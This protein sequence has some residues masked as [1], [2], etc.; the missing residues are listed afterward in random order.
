MP[1]P[2]GA[3]VPGARGPRRSPPLQ[4]FSSSSSSS[5]RLCPEPATATSPRRR[6]ECPQER[7]RHQAGAPSASSPPS[8]PLPSPVAPLQLLLRL[9]LTSGLLSP[10]WSPRAPD[11][12][13]YDASPPSSATRTTG[14]S[15]P[16]PCARLPFL[17]RRLPSSPC[18][19]AG[20]CSTSS[21][22]SAHCPSLPAAAPSPRSIW[23]RDPEPCCRCPFCNRGELRHRFPLSFPS[24][25]HRSH[26]PTTAEPPPSR[27]SSPAPFR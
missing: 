9:V 11:Q 6:H 24:F 23:T 18:L 26:L 2:H 22:L 14:Q 15:R 20:P 12:Q 5:P 10:T 7:Q 17:P 1:D 8:R 13:A 3:P 27:T 21:R 16:S 4:F 19:V 25:P